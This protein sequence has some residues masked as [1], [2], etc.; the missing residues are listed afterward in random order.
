M[1]TILTLLII[2]VLGAAGLTQVPLKTAV[3]TMHL[4][5]FGLTASE[6]DGNLWSG[7]LLNA[8]LGKVPLGDVS[9]NMS[10]ADLAKG[11]VKL[12]IT[13]TD[14]VSQLKGAFG[15]GIG[16][17]GVEGF[18]LGVSGLQG[19]P[20]MPPATLVLDGLTAHF[21]GGECA[22]AR[23]SAR[24]SLSGTAG[25]LLPMAGMSGP[26]LCREG[27]LVFD[28]ASDSGHEQEVITIL[29]ANRYRVRALIKSAPLALAARLQSAGFVATPDG[30]VYEGERTL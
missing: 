16:G 15:Y 4:G 19:A 14:P 20:M 23:G 2:L 6:I 13:G 22:E 9:S 10:F 11:R 3:E 5:K 28:M 21:P 29:S 27:K 18:N 24:V 8:Q 12:V 1:K 7:H 17:A 30:F 26:A 25:G